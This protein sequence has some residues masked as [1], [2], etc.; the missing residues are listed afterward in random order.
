MNLE[1]ASF[2]YW[3]TLIGILYIFLIQTS[4]FSF[5]ILSIKSVLRYFRLVQSSK[6]LT[7][8]ETEFLP[9]ISIIVPAFNE[10]LTI[11]ENVKGFV[12]IDYAK[13]EIIVV[14]DGSTDDTFQMLKE[15]F[16]L[17]PIDKVYSKKLESMSIKQ[18]YYSL[19]Y[20]QLIV[21]NKDNG[22]KAD[23]INAG[24]NVSQYPLFCVVD[25][26]S[27]LERESLIRV[28]FPFIENPE[29]VVGVGGIVRIANGCKIKDGKITE[30]KPPRNHWARLQT[31]EYLRAFL[32]GRIPW[33]EI[34][35]LLIIAGAFSVFKKDA[36]IEIGGYMTDTVGEDMEITT[37]L[38]RFRYEN[39]K[40]WS[41]KFVPDPVCWSQAPEDV[42]T[43][44]NQR[45]RWHRGLAET[46]WKHRKMFLNPKYGKVGMLAMPYFV[47]IELLAPIIE[48][49]GLIIVP[50]QYFIGVVDI[51]FALA[52]LTI[53]VFY[54]QII[55]VSSLLIEEYTYKR[56]KHFPDF[57]IL[58]FYSWIEGSYFRLLNSWWKLNAIFH[59]RSKKKSWGE[60]QK[61]SFDS[62]P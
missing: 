28:V 47:F 33:S 17:I 32:F 41:I 43:L 2:Y 23:S 22:G 59:V 42:K 56:Y 16:H 31:I 10:A 35:S 30:I 50:V 14:N 55:S 51:W 36:I 15:A 3:F 6:Y 29:E 1:L 52:A 40:K 4:Y 60:M 54:G 45:S 21:V 5:L 19:K 58:Y 11:I 24:I 20:P 46:L 13:Y 9:P 37:R 53:L 38:H 57:I 48:I 27:I 18:I 49:A 39:N 26:D 12:A 44:K 61:K 34:N 8:N 62:T 25:A 7:H